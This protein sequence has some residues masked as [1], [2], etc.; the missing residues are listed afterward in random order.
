MVELTQSF[1]QYSSHTL[2]CVLPAF[3]LLYFHLMQSIYFQRQDVLN[4]CAD[5]IEPVCKL[6]TVEKV[7][8]AL[9]IHN[10]PL[11]LKVTHKES[12]QNCSQ[13]VGPLTNSQL[14]VKPSF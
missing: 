1:L 3:L 14:I 4:I 13:C 11:Y 8:E 6:H 5:L 12:W 9:A 2:Y 7:Y 10:Q